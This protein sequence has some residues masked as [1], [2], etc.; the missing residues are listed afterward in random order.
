M[1]KVTL[2]LLVVGML[3]TTGCAITKW[4]CASN[5]C[6]SR[7]RASN[8]C[9]AQ[10]NSAFASSSAKS[11]IWSQ[12]MRGEGFAEVTCQPYERDRDYCRPMVLHVF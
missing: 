7:D 11:S 2:F 9:L 8:K 3:S 10:A 12:C 4:E 1:K 5:D 6:I